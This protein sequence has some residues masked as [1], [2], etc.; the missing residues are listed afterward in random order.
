MMKWLRTIAT[1]TFGLFVDDGAFAVAILAW[2]IVAGVVLPHVGTTAAVKGP[3]LFA[4]LAVILIESA[5][6]RA[7][8]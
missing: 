2:L 5:T 7:R 4:G 6:R 1:E 8:K 3:I